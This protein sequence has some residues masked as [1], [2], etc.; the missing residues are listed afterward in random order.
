[1][2]A[3]DSIGIINN[4]LLKATGT[5]SFALRSQQVSIGMPSGA[6]ITNNGTLDGRISLTAGGGELLTNSGL[7]T[8]TSSNIPVAAGVFS[9]TNSSD[10]AQTATL[11]PSFPRDGGGETNSFM[12][13]GGGGTA[14]LAGTLRA[15]VQAGLYGAATVYAGVLTAAGGRTGTFGSVVS[16]RRSSPRAPPI[17]EP[18]STLR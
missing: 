10:F 7:I 17:P 18:T 4:G 1:M 14:T 6:N 16:R 15:N 9:I 8:I 13:T 12:I 3:A 5:T 2:G 11:A